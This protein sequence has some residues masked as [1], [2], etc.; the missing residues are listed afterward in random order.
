MTAARATHVIAVDWGSTHVR[1]ELWQ[2]GSRLDSRS[3]ADGVLGFRGRSFE[4]ALGELCGD[5]L[6]AHPTAEVFLSGMIGSR[7]GWLDVPHVVLPAGPREVAA[8]MAVLPSSRWKG[9]LR[10]APGLKDLSRSTPDLMRGEE[11]QVLGALAALGKEEGVFCLP[12]THSKWVR[13]AGGRITAF[14]TF[15]TGEM[16][17]A[18]LRMGLLAALLG[19]TQAWDEGAFRQGLESSGHALGLTHHIFAARARVLSGTLRPGGL[20]A[21]LSGLLVGQELR[22]AQAWMGPARGS[23]ALVAAPDLLPVY[24]T[25][26]AVFGWEVLSVDVPC[27]AL[28]ARVILAARPEVAP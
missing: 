7:E 4:D 15:A 14:V 12:G 9:R 13:V 2:E 19:D 26:L 5:W 17:Q 18:V 1:A 28:G 22:G 11:T 3:S 23:V 25:A 20:R 6:D 8:G 27:H 21:F 24:R 10:A 16:F